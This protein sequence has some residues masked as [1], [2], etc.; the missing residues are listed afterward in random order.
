MLSAFY[1]F[2]RLGF[3]LFGPLIGLD[4]TEDEKI[5]VLGQIYENRRFAI[6]MR[7]PKGYIISSKKKWLNRKLVDHLNLIYIIV[8][9]LIASF[10]AII[11]VGK[12]ARKR[13]SRNSVDKEERDARLRQLTEEK[14]AIRAKEEELLVEHPYFKIKK[15]RIK[16]EKATEAGDQTAIAGF[17]EGIDA[18]REEYKGA[19]EE[20]LEKAY[21]AQ[22][23]VMKRRLSRI[24]IEMREI[25]RQNV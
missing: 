8:G 16:R 5:V 2:R 19:T 22:L 7:S 4:R 21:H 15:L 18:I 1:A 11:I 3:V 20:Q 17:D 6:D 23:G 14:S 24:E 13:N 10:A 12:I 25:L 9:A